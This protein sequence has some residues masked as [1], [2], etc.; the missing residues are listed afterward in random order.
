MSGVLEK[1]VGGKAGKED[2]TLAFFIGNDGKSAERM[3]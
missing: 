2:I 1:E 3:G